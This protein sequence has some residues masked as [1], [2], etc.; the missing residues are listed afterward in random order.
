MALSEPQEREG[1]GITWAKC[2]DTKQ[3]FVHPILGPTSFDSNLAMPC[4]RRP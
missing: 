2:T 3:A 4:S 1:K